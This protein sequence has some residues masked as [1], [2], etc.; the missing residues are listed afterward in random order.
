VIDRLLQ[1]SNGDRVAVEAQYHRKKGCLSKF[2][3]TNLKTP[4]KALSDKCNPVYKSAAEK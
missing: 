1:V 3:D 4:E 2:Y